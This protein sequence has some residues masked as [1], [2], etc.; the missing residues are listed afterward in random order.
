MPNNLFDN[1]LST[2]IQIRE[3]E[4]LKLNYKYYTVITC[5][6]VVQYESFQAERHNTT[7]YWIGYS[8]RHNGSL[9]VLVVCP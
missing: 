9:Y 1:V 4:E 2:Y 6:S 5:Y 7:M 8:T 3:I